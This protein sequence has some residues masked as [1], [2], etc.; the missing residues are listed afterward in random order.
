G[1]R[2]R[3]RGY[4]ATVGSRPCDTHADRE[5]RDG[6]EQDGPD[7]GDGHLLSTN[8]S[9]APNLGKRSESPVNAVPRRLALS[10]WWRALPAPAAPRGTARRAGT[11]WPAGCR[12]AP[13]RGSA[14]AR[15]P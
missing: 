6:H 4:R 7:Q 3:G 12:S 11:A 1:R 13:R 15:P 9:Y 14:A 10:G 8:P 2:R 5:G